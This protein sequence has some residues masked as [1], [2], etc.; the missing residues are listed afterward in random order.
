MILAEVAGT[1][2]CTVKNEQYKG[3]RILIVHPVDAAGNRKGKSFLAVDGVQAGPGDLVLVFDEGGTARSI[4]D[5]EECK[6]IRT[7][8]GGIVD[9]VSSETGEY[10]LK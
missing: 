8:I 7:V 9:T 6:A 1:V 5:C 2:T 4:L 3:K 10:K